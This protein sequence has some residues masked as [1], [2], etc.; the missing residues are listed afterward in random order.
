MVT[1]AAASSASSAG[2]PVSV[3]AVRSDSAGGSPDTGASVV[4]LISGTPSASASQFTAGPAAGEER[5]EFTIS[6]SAIATSVLCSACGGAE[7]PMTSSGVEY[8]A[9]GLA[10][11]ASTEGAGS[12]QQARWVSCGDTVALVVVCDCSVSSV[13]LVLS[14][15]AGVPSPPTSS[16]ATSRLLAVGLPRLR[17]RE[18]LPRP[19]RAPRPP[20]RPRVGAGLGNGDASCGTS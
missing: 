6:A 9:A 16:F 1:D 17:P 13:L 12:E 2:T 20:R 7:T 14:S 8:A 4:L 10:C 5:S 18:E 3:V 15:A 11:T 19:P